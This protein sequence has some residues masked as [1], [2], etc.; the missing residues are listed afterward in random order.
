MVIAQMNSCGTPEN[1]V[2]CCHYDR[3][4]YLLNYLL[5][6]L[7]THSDGE[8]HTTDNLLKLASEGRMM[9]YL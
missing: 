8:F 9:I 5:N 7:V 6:Y 3:S 2:L 4:F 1:R